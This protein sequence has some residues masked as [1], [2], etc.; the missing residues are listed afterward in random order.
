MGSG[1]NIPVKI[2]K[3]FKVDDKILPCA[4]YGPGSYDQADYFLF[5]TFHPDM[6]GGTGENFDWGV[7]NREKDRLTKPFLVAGGLDPKN[8]ASVIKSVYPYGVDTSSGVE[9][10]PGEKDANLLKEFIKNAKET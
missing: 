7:L 10:S 2:I 5:D 4:E 8:V 9:A 6:A 1:H 3:V